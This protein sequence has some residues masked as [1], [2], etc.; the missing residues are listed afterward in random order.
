MNNLRDNNL[1]DLQIQ[2]LLG[3]FLQSRASSNNLSAPGEHLDDDSF[4]TFVEGTLSE[5]EAEPI[6]NHLADCSYC[7]HITG[8]L[9]KLKFAFADETVE[10]A[11]IRS[12][13]SK[14]S[15]VL[16]NLLSRIFGS[17]ESAV[18]AH[19]ETNPETSEEA[20]KSENI[21]ENNK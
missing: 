8:E 10:V 18:F 15:E 6:F 11:Q 5:R 9:I 19:E 3:V 4:A 1:Q 17:G 13:P 20:E 7:L 12:E 16:S 14:V 2:K 21:E